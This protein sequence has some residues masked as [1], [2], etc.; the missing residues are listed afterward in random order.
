MRS[1]AQIFSPRTHLLAPTMSYDE[2]LRKINSPSASPEE[3]LGDLKRAE[4]ALELTSEDDLLLMHRRAKLGSILLAS[5]TSVGHWDPGCHGPVLQSRRL[6]AW[7]AEAV[8]R[9]DLCPNNNLR[10]Q[11]LRF[12]EMWS[13]ADFR[14]FGEKVAEGVVSLGACLRVEHLIPGFY[15]S[16]TPPLTNVLQR[17]Q[18]TGHALMTLMMLDRALR[19]L[20]IL[21]SADAVRAAFA[22]PGLAQV[23]AAVLVRVTRMG[24]GDVGG[25]LDA[26]RVRYKDILFKVGKILASF[27]AA[28]APG[29]HTVLDVLR[30]DHGAHVAL[31]AAKLEQVGLS[32]PDLPPPDADAEEAF[33]E[34]FVDSVTQDLMEAPVRLGSSG[35]VVDEAT[36]IHLQL[37]KPLDPFTR[38]PLALD[39]HA[40]LPL[41][42][43]R[44]RAW[45]L[46]CAKR[47]EGEAADKK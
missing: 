17:L 45:R 43:E 31:V 47:R 15:S 33:P 19:I 22:S 24:V 14:D 35:M 41:L 6:K 26:D 34:E 12:L 36:L 7:L 28:G 46:E 32:L 11:L 42:Q 16:L 25:L 1:I 38:R 5:V 18:R 13:D 40:R 3:I 30:R 44:L 2:I 4:D 23:L 10:L 27:R 37:V 39:T 9:R 8:T 29:R 20:Q 21:T